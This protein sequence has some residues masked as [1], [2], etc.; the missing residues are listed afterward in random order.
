MPARLQ[1]R[2]RYGRGQPVPPP[3]PPPSVR[4]LLV[5]DSLTALSYGSL[6]P[7]TWSL[8][9]NGGYLQP[10]A[11]IAIAGNTVGD[12]LARIDNSYTNATPGAAG[13]GQL[14][15]FI[16][17]AGANDF[18]GGSSINSTIQGQYDSLISKLLTYCTRGV[19]CALTPMSA[20]ENGAGVGGANAW[21]SS[22]CA[23]NSRLF[24]LDDCVTVNNGSGGWASG[25][26]PGDGI[27]TTNAGSYRMGID[28]AAALASHLGSFG[29]AS[30]L[31]TD[32]AD[33]YPAQPQWVAT[34]LMAGTG[35]S[36]GL[37]GGGA[38]AT[39]W[40]VGAAGA[41][42]N[43]TCEKVASV[44]A[45]PT[46]W[47]RINPTQIQ[48]NGTDGGLGMSVALTGRT[49][50]DTDPDSLDVVMEVRMTAL[51]TQRFRYLRV[52][53]YG[54]S[55]EDLAPPMYLRMGD[56]PTTGTAVMRCAIRRSG[57]RVAHSAAQ[58]NITLCSAEAFTGGMGSIDFRCVTV[59]G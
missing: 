5:G 20:P 11:N 16:L 39:G 46:P 52:T 26:V 45:N 27:H 32:G 21:L 40:S 1:T 7:Y 41:N 10:V 8:G 57:T 3:P 37:A 17:R 42:I 59:R 19:V 49:I 38:V 6:H 34:H 12:I 50:T 29:Y 4:T 56:G 28:G 31:S 33:V 9:L 15:W 48:D 54:A 55:N 14:G 43:G 18:R 25:Y 2:T 36:N 22:Y 13:L 35:G 23:A 58:L 30:P 47:Q 51:Q 44:D 24:Y 53:P